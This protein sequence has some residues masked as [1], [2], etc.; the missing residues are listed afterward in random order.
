[1]SLSHL[2]SSK[3]KSRNKDHFAAIVRI[4]LAD[5]EIT[6]EE[7]AFINRTA[8]NLE[9]EESEVSSIIENINDY[10]I[11]PPTSKKARLE[12]LY[13]L[14]RMVFA[15][16]IADNDEKKLMYR[17]VVNLGFDSDNAESIV[18]KSFGEIEKGSDEDEFIAAF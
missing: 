3:F 14:S 16:N 6:D 5:G 15:D 7:Q 9:I 10:P 13:D 12:R 11:I 1:M 2:Y 18:E 8:I 4:A 17:L